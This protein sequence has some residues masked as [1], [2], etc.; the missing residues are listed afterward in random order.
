MADRGWTSQAQMEKDPQDRIGE[1]I[2]TYA[3]LIHPKHKCQDDQPV[4]WPPKD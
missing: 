4:V 2:P 1:C 3:Y